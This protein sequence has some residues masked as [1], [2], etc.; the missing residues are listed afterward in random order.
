[1]SCIR[2]LEKLRE[3]DISIWEEDGKLRYTAPRGALTEELRA[4]IAAYRADLL[5][6][7]SA[8]RAGEIR[9]APRQDGRRPLSYGQE[10]L[11]FI[12]QLNPGSVAY[13]V[14]LQTRVRGELDPS[15]LRLALREIVRRHEPLGVSFT[16]T[17]GSPVVSVGEPPA[18]VL[19]EASLEDVPAPDRLAE[20][21][22]RGR[23]D[24]QRPFDLTR[25]PL[26]RATLYRLGEGDHV[27]EQVFHFK[28]D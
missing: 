2:L 17:D 21:L 25:G 5:V 22:R 28:V 23:A 8:S 24:R 1:M 13:N 27:F 9:R 15:A 18:A 7:L 16:S 3:R 10:Q 12:D 26:F 19:L 14:A 11:W 6:L 4:E 20:V